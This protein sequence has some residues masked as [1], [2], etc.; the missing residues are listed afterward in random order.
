VHGRRAL[1]LAATLALVAAALGALVPATRAATR[2]PLRDALAAARLYDRAQDSSI[3]PDTAALRA[4]LRQTAHRYASAADEFSIASDH[5]GA[6]EVESVAAVLR[7]LDHGPEIARL[8]VLVATPGEIR[9]ACGD[10]VLA[11]YFPSV[12]EMLV[13]G[14]DR[15]VDGVPR[16]FAIAHEYGHHVANTRASGASPGVEGGTL[17]WATYE[18]VCQLSRRGRLF[19]GEQGARYWLNPEE[20]FAQAYAFLNRP[21]DR[22]VW[23]YTPLLRPTAASLARIHADVAHPWTGPVESRWGGTLAAPAQPAAAAGARSG[24][25]GVGAGRAV[26][27]PPWL[28]TRVLRTPLDGLVAVSVRTPAGAR[29]SVTLRDRELGRPLARG[30][31]GPDGRAE[32]SYSNCGADVLRVEVR[33]IDGPASFEAELTRP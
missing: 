29:V 22:V 3:R 4:M 31:T 13:S 23:D 5:Y 20:A 1:H 7:S 12:G 15:P 16:D 24:A 26:G 32:I 27:D 6:A 30:V 8:S 10:A 17:R 21:D 33:A 9:E 25:I 14:V 18:R 2:E 11:C 28:A 19:P